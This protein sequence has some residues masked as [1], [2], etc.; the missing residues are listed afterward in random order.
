MSKKKD[1]EVDKWI[2]HITINKGG[3]LSAKDIEKAANKA[4]KDFGKLQTILVSPQ[5]LAEIMKLA[6][7]D[8]HFSIEGK[9]LPTPDEIFKDILKDVK[10]TK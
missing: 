3:T 6:Y 5:E 4:L 2:K 1:P 8:K 10:E 7:G 9:G